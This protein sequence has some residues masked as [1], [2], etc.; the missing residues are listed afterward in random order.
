MKKSKEPLI[1]Q[2]LKFRKERDWKKFHTPKSLAISIAIETS[3]LLSIFQ[4][5]KDDELKDLI[6][7]KF[8]DIKDE[9]ADIYIYLILL[10]HDLGLDLEEAGKEKMVVNT[11]R[12][13]VSKAKG[14]SKKYTEF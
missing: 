14:S 5:V 9:I 13:P 6:K 12:Y 2:M 7:E 4:W 10:A 11:K 1:E 3:E 8:S